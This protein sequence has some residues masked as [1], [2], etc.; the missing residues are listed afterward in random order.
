M[1]GEMRGE[2]AASFL[3]MLSTGHRGS[4]ATLH[5]HNAQDALR[6]L[7]MLIQMG[8]Q[9]WNL[10]TVRQL[11]YS[12]LNFLITMGRTSSGKRCVSKVSQIEGL[13]D[14]GFLTHD[15]YDNCESQIF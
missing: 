15:L 12:S 4:G 2:E 3:L 9:N 11:I 5:A 1:M 7:E 6:R 10:Q 8:G 13:E 14:H